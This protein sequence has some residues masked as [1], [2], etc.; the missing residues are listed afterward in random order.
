MMPDRLHTA[1]FA[2]VTIP[3]LL[4][5]TTGSAEAGPTACTGGSTVTC[6]GNQS[7]GITSGTD[8]D[9]NVVDRLQ[10]RNLTANIGPFTSSIAWG[11][12]WQASASNA[13]ASMSLDVLSQQFSIVTMSGLGAGIGLDSAR[14]NGSSGSTN[15]TGGTG[16]AGQA[17]RPISASSQI[18]ITA[19]AFSGGAGIDLEVA[20]GQW[21]QRRH[22]HN[23]KRR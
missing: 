18:D 3:C 14:S 8:F 6:M 20:R 2:I 23:R 21:R 19:L 10:V 7:A 4:A 22:R 11:I 5:L 15:P 13:P 9:P 17:G 16:G 12:L 1:W